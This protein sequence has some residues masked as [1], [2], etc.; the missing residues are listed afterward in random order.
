MGSC[1]GSTLTGDFSDTLLGGKTAALNKAIDVTHQ[2]IELLREYR[3]RLI[4]DVVTGKL[5]V[6][7]AAAGLPDEPLEPEA[8]HETDA[9]GDAD[10]ET[11]IAENLEG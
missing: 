2:E 1:Q 10:E 7:E 9:L 3:T 6:R 11:E 8:L 4:A 5:D